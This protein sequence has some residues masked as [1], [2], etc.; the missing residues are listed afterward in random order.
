M[1]K[2]S[3]ILPVFNSEEYLRRSIESVLSQSFHDFELIIV[4]DGSTDKSLDI[5]QEYEVLDSRVTVVHQ[6]NSGVSKARNVAL[7]LCRGEFITFIDSD[8]SYTSNY[9]ETL[10]HTILKENA[11][12][13]ICD[14]TAITP[15]GEKEIESISSFSKNVT[16]YRDDI[17][18]EILLEIA[19]AVWRCMYKTSLLI[20]HAIRFPLGLKI[21]EDRIFNIIAI[22]RATKISYLKVS[23]Y[24]RMLVAEST[25]HRFHLDYWQTIKK[26]KDATKQALYNVWNNDTSFQTAYLN[27]FIFG[28]IMAIENFKRSDNHLS[29]IN[30]YRFIR[31]ICND[32]DLQYA[33]RITSYTHKDVK[34]KWIAKKQIPLL[35]MKSQKLYWQYR[36]FKKIFSADFLHR[37]FKKI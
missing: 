25:V 15:S 9:I 27:Q 11:Q 21:A 4:D 37:L 35:M 7:G 24:N 36:R 10:Y 16:L 2:V 23:L 26:G 30:K 31:A 20:E 6:N 29:L 32:K 1:P 13:C 14:S 18:P 8:D 19:G 5:I 3:V 17:T 12:I 28:A 34:A 33:I 22:G